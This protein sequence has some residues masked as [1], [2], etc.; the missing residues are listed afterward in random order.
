[1]YNRT[2]MGKPASVLAG[3]NTFWT[4]QERVRNKI[5]GDQADYERSQVS[6]LDKYKNEVI[7]AKKAE[8]KEYERTHGHS[9]NFFTDFKFGVGSANNQFLK[10]FNKYVAPAISMA[11]PVGAAVAKSTQSVSGVVDRLT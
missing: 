3:N 2:F 9:G 11:G 8:V 10:P 6:E 4:E 7:N 5:L 1:M